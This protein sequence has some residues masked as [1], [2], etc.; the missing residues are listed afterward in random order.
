M[1]TFYII[2]ISSFF[3][4]SYYA[5]P[6]Q[7]TSL[8]G[9]P[10]N[11]LYGVLSMLLKLIRDYKPD[12]MAAGFDT[13]TPS[14][15]KE[16]FQEY[17]ANRGEMPEDLEKQVPWLKKMI[18]ILNIY[19][20]EK[21]GYEADDIIGT[22]ARWG[23]NH[24]LKIFIV[25][26]D[27]DFAQ[28][29]DQNTALLD[30]MKSKMYYQEDVY[31]KWKVYPEQM[32]DYQALTGDSS[33][34]IPGV[35]GIGPKGAATLLKEYKNLDNIY[36]NIN[37]INKNIQKKLKEG[38]KE[39]LLSKQLV[40]II[41]DLKLNC[42]LSDLAF[43]K[44]DDIQFKSFLEELNFNTFLKAL[45]P[46]KNTKKHK[47]TV[48]SQKQMTTNCWTEGDMARQLEPYAS[49][50]LGEWK[51][52]IYLGHK[53]QLIE[54]ASKDL[55]NFGSILDDKWIRWSG[56]DLKFL[57]KK[58]ELKNPLPEWDS[59]VAGHLLDSRPSNSFH[60]LCKQY[61]QSE[62]KPDSPETLYQRHLQL[63]DVLE[64]KL[65]ILNLETLFK[66]VELPLIPVLYD[67]ENHGIL[68]NK[69][70]VEGQSAQLDK[71]LK[72][73]E[74]NI[75]QLCGTTFNLASPKQLGEV[76]FDKLNLPQGRKTKS[77]HSTDSR[78][79]IKLKGRHPVLPLILEYRELF[80]L[81]TTYT[82]SLIE[83]IHPETRRIHTSFRQ[84]ATATGRLS[85][86]HPNLQN[87]PIKTE[88]G[89]QIRRAFTVPEG[90]VLV[91]ADYS[92]IELRI[93][94]HITE[95]PGLLRAFQ[96]G[97]D[98]HAAT[99]SEIFNVPLKEIT[100]ELRRKSKAVNFGIAYGQGAYGLSES[101][102]ISR[103]EGKVIID[104]YFKKFKKVQD[105]IETA[106]EISK[107]YVETLFGRKRFFA[108]WELT[109]PKMRAASERAAINAPIQGTASDIVKKAMIELDQ[110]LPL[111]LVSQ[112]H[113]ELLFECPKDQWE[114][115]KP[116]IIS[117][118]E[119][120]VRLKASLKVNCVAGS[121]WAE[122]HL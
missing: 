69:K 121:H 19:G 90:F 63:K 86:V 78:E 108:D 14:F 3:F 113:D 59:M 88:R 45:Y 81:K 106:K 41:Q 33:D 111:S 43:K 23:T 72:G 54:L 101:L 112:V 73:L 116:H 27:K 53:K 94:A 56:Y 103:A 57:W 71:D 6:G 96:E 18:Q 117:I 109:N 62:E 115:E 92:Q 44:P 65:K 35:K 100:P 58:L 95:D 102:G 55:K 85:S 114:E 39:A 38:K 24:N 2:D 110:S 4:R 32:I 1:K 91:S 105:Y 50:W 49:L 82:T 48:T 120:C 21:E 93:L 37:K 51:D 87:I 7:M 20:V 46:E 80:K 84:T 77:G 66:E 67:M 74:A 12:Y 68:L 9:L 31:A 34:N 107:G 47:K 16:I 89:K 30:T 61:L 36:N 76:L 8:S 99:A 40:T 5:I 25:S 104:S 17:K 83:L 22:L 60:F 119:N 13:K 70:E 42:T 28:L 75:F 26:G 52:T 11:A 98:I 97:Q 10:T 29:V 79:L 15:R 122:A 64:R 118:M